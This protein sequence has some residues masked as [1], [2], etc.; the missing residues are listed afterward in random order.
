MHKTSNNGKKGDLKDQGE[1]RNFISDQLI[2]IIAV[3]AKQQPLSL[4]PPQTLNKTHIR[5]QLFSIR[6]R[7]SKSV[8]SYIHS[9]RL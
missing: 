1:Y 2:P 9:F 4:S 5:T 6:E 7:R 3:R 8:I